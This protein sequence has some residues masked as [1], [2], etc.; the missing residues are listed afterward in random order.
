[1]HRI[2]V[3][4]LAASAAGSATALASL[5]TN[6][7]DPSAKLSA[8]GREVSVGGPIACDAGE[9]LTL[10]ARVTQRKTGALATGGF[11]TI[12][13]GQVGRWEVPKAKALGRNRFRPGIA[14]GC[15]L[16][17]TWMGDRV[18]DAHQWCAKN[19]ITLSRRSARAAGN[20]LQTIDATVT[21]RPDGRTL[22][23]SGPLACT[24]GERV[25]VDARVTQR[26]TGALAEGRWR[27]ICTG[28]RQTW[29]VRRAAT[30]HRERF[31]P[32]AAEA[33]GLLLT[34]RRGRVTDAHQ[35]CRTD[36]VTI[37][38]Q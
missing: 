36:G 13:T 37:V 26:Q 2:V 27:G 23:V 22:I 14:E 24:R 38:K 3:V 19:G 12:C 1:M 34:R 32:G 21:V 15:A 16:A 30:K 20:T 11:V 17:L 10:R 8:N 28:E 6:T 18:T 33:C 9:R 31:A 29:R 7:F 5:T 4:A 25:T 35:W